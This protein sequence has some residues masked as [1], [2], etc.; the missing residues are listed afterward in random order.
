MR[1]YTYLSNSSVGFAF[2]NIGNPPVK[3]EEDFF[4]LGDVRIAI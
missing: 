3:A 4:F 1:S 2:G